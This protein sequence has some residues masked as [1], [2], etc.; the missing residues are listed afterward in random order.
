MKV[1]VEFALREICIARLTDVILVA[2]CN[3]ASREYTLAG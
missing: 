2:R 3:S 1:H